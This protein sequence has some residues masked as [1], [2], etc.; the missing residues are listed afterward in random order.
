MNDEIDYRFNWVGLIIKIVIFIVLILLAIWVVSMTFNKGKKESNFDDNFEKF[1]SAALNYFESDNLPTEENEK[2][3]LTLD[4]MIKKGI[5]DELLDQDGK[6]CD[7]SN[8]YVEAL[9]KDGYYE[10]TAKLIC[11]EDEKITKNKINEEQSE[12][13]DN[14]DNTTDNNGNTTDTNDSNNESNS[15]TNNGANKVTYYEYVKVNKKYTP[16]QLKKISGDNVESKTDTMSI[17]NDCKVKDVEYYSTGYVTKNSPTNITYTVK[18]LDIP[19]SA[20]NVKILGKKY[21]NNDLSYY[22]AYKNSS[23]LSMVGVDDKYKVQIPELYTYRA[24]SLKSNNFSFTVSNLRKS[25]NYYTVDITVNIRNKYNVTPYYSNNL[26]AYVYFV[27]LYFY[28]QYTDMNSCIED[29]N[30]NATA[31]T[32]YKIY[33]THKEKVTVYRSYSLEKDY[34]DVKWSSASSLDGYVKTGNTELR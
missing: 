24:A 17:S 31:Y 12:N 30:E 29:T 16:W 13:K 27:P 4:A 5:I 9:K 19:N 33:N 3:T 34:N 26:K 15:T 8:S 6:A 18:L 23:N 25:S 28:G 1:N 2:I 11:G 22:E 7:K 20:N 21:F 14:E 32:S 10:I